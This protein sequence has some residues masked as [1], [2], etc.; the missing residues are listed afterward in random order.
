MVVEWLE[1]FRLKLSVQLYQIGAAVFDL[2][3]AQCHQALFVLQ[4]LVLIL[5]YLRVPLFLFWKLAYVVFLGKNLNNETYLI[6][7]FFSM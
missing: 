3:F 7:R 5:E 1:Y 4:K 2:H 6:F